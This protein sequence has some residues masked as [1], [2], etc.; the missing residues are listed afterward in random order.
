[1]HISKQATSGLGCKWLREEE[2]ED[3]GF[4]YQRDVDRVRG[5]KDSMGLV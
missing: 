3:K 2:E 1:M 4:L 5:M